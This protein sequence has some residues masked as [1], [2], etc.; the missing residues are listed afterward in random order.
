MKLQSKHINEI[1]KLKNHDI[2]PSN[3]IFKTGK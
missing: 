3:E 1:N 2:K